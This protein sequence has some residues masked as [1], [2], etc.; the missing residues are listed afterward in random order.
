MGVVL[1]DL[2]G[3]EVSLALQ[4]LSELKIIQDRTLIFPLSLKQNTKNILWFSLWIVTS[5]LKF[6]CF[7][8]VFGYYYFK[9]IPRGLFRSSHETLKNTPYNCGQTYI[10]FPIYTLLGCE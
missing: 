1:D 5:T 4:N 8:C 7:C 2:L 9:L 3:S 6:F 10:C